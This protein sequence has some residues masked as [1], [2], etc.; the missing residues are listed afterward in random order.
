MD[1]KDTINLPKTDFPMK[2]NL[3]EKELEILKKWEGLYEKLR[4]QRKGKQ[5]FVLHDG[6]PYAN[7]NIHIGHALN[8]ILKDIICKV[9]LIEGFDVDYKP[10][11][12]CHG[13]P[14]EQ[15]VEKELKAKKINK[16]SMPKDEF[17]RLCR[18]YASKF[19][20]IQKEEF[21]RLGVLGDWENPYLTMDPKYEAQEVREIGRCLQN[22]VLYKGN[23]PVYWCIYDK[24]AEAEAEVE[25]K[26]K[27]DISIYVRFELLKQS[28][29]V[30]RQK[31]DLPDK[32]ISIVIWTTTPW[33][34]PANLGVMSS[35]DIEYVVVEED[36]YLL[37][38]EKQSQYVKNKEFIAS[39]KGKELTGLE[40]QHPFIERT[41]KI[42]PSE[43]VEAGTGTGFVHMAPGHGMEDYIVGLR[44]GLEP[45]SPVDE[46]GRFTEEAPEFI[47]GL[48]VFEANTVIIEHLKQTGFLLKEEEILHSYPHCWRCKNPVI[49]RA[50]PQWFIGVDR[51]ITS[52]FASC[53]DEKIDTSDVKKL[54]NKS[55]REK[56]IEETYNVKWVP[57]TGQNRMLSMLQNRPDWCISRQRFWGVPITIF[58][59]KRCGE[60]LL[61]S[62]IFEHVAKIFESSPYGADE[63]FKKDE[64]ELLPPDTVCKK[65][66]SKD[67]VKETDILDVWFD[68]GS[69]HASVLRPRGIEKAD[70]YLEGSDQHRGWFQASLLESI[71]SYGEAPFKSVVTHGFTVDEKG[72]KMS[73][74]QGNVISPLEIIKEYGADILRLWVISEDYTEDIKLGKSI[75]KRLAEDYKKIRNTLRYC[76]GNLY[77]FKYEFSIAPDKL[78]HFDRY[79]YAYASKVFEE[80]FSFYKNYQYHRFYHRLMEF[81]SIDLSALYFDV[82]KDRLYMYKSGSF[83][84][85]S[86]QTVLYFLLKNLTILLSP[87][88]S[89]TAE[90]TYSYM[91][92][93]ENHLPESIFMNEYKASDFTD[94]ELLKDYQKLLLLR[95]DVLKAIE[96]ERK[97]DII[98]HPY[99]ARVVIKPNEEFY[100]LLEKYKD[101]LHS[102]FTVSQV[103][104]AENDGEEG[105]YTK[106]RIKVEKAKGEKCPRCW[107]Y[108]ETMIN[109]VCPR[110]SQNI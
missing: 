11:W 71:A 38:L 42:Y 8:K 20:S 25:Y 91:K 6:P 1:Y 88:L 68:S 54:Q 24:T 59:C 74:S 66:G 16:E 80:L 26:E 47:R 103:E 60:P 31:L 65:C 10:G 104:I 2:A 109:G 35:E 84:R 51:A 15:Q 63:W 28:E 17:R 49:Y 90:E 13:L 82:L 83:E 36:N 97:N 53:E 77:D 93:I 108:V 48:N 86:A 14:I 110:C 58:Y 62:H 45:F 96:I 22:G 5:L 7:G 27:K 78:H 72:H 69:S 34:L 87:V 79:M 30:L 21:L 73:K 95:K 3:S 57:K 18:E 92:S 4:A 50:T 41:G 29:N 81:V 75:L 64:K 76:L 12:D 102:F 100:K 56:A 9:A 55:I 99:E 33:T 70:V 101:Y 23:K 40:Y 43:F 106:L 46:S 61:E 19:V 32:P 94:E 44:Y 52:H 105:E 39:L 107:L 37:L 67:F 89:F 85:L 98:K